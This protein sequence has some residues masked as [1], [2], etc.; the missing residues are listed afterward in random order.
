[1][2]VRANVKHLTAYN[3]QPVV[4][5]VQD[6]YYSSF[7]KDDN[8]VN[9]LDR[10]ILVHRTKSLEPK[11]ELAKNIQASVYGIKKTS[12]WFEQYGKR[13]LRFLYRLMV[14]PDEHILWIFHAIKA[15]LDLIQK[16]DINLIYVTTPPH[17]AGIIAWIL[18]VL[19]RKPLVWDVRDDWVG[20]PLFDA[21]PWHRHQMAKLLET[22][23]V[24]RAKYV[25]S[26][27]QESITSFGTKY[28]KQ[29]AEKFA[30]IPNGYDKQEIESITRHFTHHVTSKLRI[31][32]TGTLGSTR[33]PIPLFEA[34]QQLNADRLL[35]DRLSIDFFG[36][37]RQ[38]F[39]DKS[40]L[41]GLSRIVRFHGF[42]SR[43]ASLQQIIMS[44]AALLII[45]EAEGSR[46]AIPGKLY[47]YIGCG[48]FILA[49]CPIDSAASHL[50]QHENVGIVVNQYDSSHIRDAIGQLLSMHKEQKLLCFYDQSL[51][52]FDRFRQAQQLANL[53][54]QL[55]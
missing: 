24:R 36:Y 52:R 2:R 23:L 48:K 16:Q 44:D 21:G 27:T 6:D 7:T 38:D 34:L 47:E 17:S 14:I 30:F 28:P 10:S 53:F 20:N 39:I 19:S 8:L 3:W 11:G 43:E 40:S 51:Q 37:A 55:V 15:G 49:L 22:L 45:P 29:L 50:I 41:M 1:M 46:T 5:T 9:E 26:V 33:T 25:I 31:V 12:V 54:D 42:V 13:I 32:Y 4:L 18:S 35:E